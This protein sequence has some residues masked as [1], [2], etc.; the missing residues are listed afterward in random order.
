MGESDFEHSSMAST[1]WV[2]VDV[3]KSHKEQTDGGVQLHYWGGLTDS[4]HISHRTLFQEALK[5]QR[6]DSSLGGRNPLRRLLSWLQ[7][8]FF[9]LHLH[10][11]VFF[12]YPPLRC[13]LRF[14]W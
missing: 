11:K 1:S 5:I 4:E 9:V 13:L 3:G 12:W 14:L 7:R 6:Q 8:I 2:Y 10:K